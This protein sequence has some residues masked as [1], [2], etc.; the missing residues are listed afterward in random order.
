[1]KIRESREVPL[2]VERDVL[3]VDLRKD[4]TESIKDEVVVESRI[5]LHINDR[6]YAVF[7]FSPSEIK[8]LAVGHLL[9]EGIIDGLEEIKS[10]EISK[11]RVDVYLT[12]KTKPPSP[13]KPRLI[14]TECGSGVGYVPARLWMNVKGAKGATSLRFNSQIIV[15]TMKTLNSLTDMFKRTGGTHASALLDENGSVLAFSEDV[16]RHNAIDKA[17]GKAALE[18]LDF[19]KTLL[20]STGRLTSEMVIKAAQVAIPVIVS[21]SAP[22]DKGIKIA[23]MT[24]LTLIGFVRGNRFNVYSHPGRIVI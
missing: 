18:G 19:K 20:A 4:S 6:H 14:Q 11:G 3:R 1:M 8:E 17:I 9:A 22:T 2:S 23:E 21:I 10:L 12:K 5:E 13:E 15:G 7:I 16:G 24:G